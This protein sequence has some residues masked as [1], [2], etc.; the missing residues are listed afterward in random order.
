MN[1]SAEK[2]IITVTANPSWMYP[3]T[4]NHPLS[5]AEIADEVYECY[6]AGATIAHLHAPS[7]NWAEI[8]ERIRAKCDIILQ[9]GL[10]GTPLDKRKEQFSLKPDMMSIILTHHDEQLKDV[11]LN[12]LHTKEE[13]TEYCRLCNE[14]GVKPEFETWHHGAVWNLKYLE[15]EGLVKKPYFLS[16]FF[17]WG[18]GSWSPPTP[19]ELLHRVTYLPDGSMYTTSVMDPAQMGLLALTIFIGGHVRV[20][21]E[22]YPFLPGGT[23][24]PNSGLVKR[25]AD[26]SRNLG[27]EVA[28]VKEARESIGLP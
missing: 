16:L 20:G 24:V 3:E 21:T 14:N 23:I 9:F 7:G 4:K 26:L 18:G 27:R 2:L 11:S 10:S 15:E 28:N 12:E 25:V 6:K 19:D 22:D 13:L 1:R 5:P 8:S 17:G